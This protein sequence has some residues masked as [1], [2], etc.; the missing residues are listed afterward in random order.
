MKRLFLLIIAFI[1]FISPSKAQS[2]NLEAAIYNI[3]IGS[4]FSACGALIN[5]KKDEKFM[6]VIY[7][8]LWQGGMGGYLTFESKSD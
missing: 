4:L 5:K 8:G 1:V 2:N 6:P 7:K 3:G